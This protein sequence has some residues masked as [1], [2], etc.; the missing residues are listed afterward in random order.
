MEIEEYGLANVQRTGYPDGGMSA[1]EE[2]IY[3]RLEGNKKKLEKLKSEYGAV[4]E[5]IGTSQ[6]LGEDLKRALR[7]LYEFEIEIT[8]WWITYDESA[9]EVIRRF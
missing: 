5:A 7:D 4:D 8:E 6:F 2:R 3:N 9:L 1:R